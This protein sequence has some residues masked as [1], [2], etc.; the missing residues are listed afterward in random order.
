MKTI[1]ILG[2]GCPSC[3]ATEDVVR[4]ALQQSGKEAAVEKVEDIQEIMKYNVLTTPVLVVDEEI[5]IKGRV[6]DV[7][8]VIE[9]LL[10]SKSKY[11]K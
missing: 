8:E 2:M 4:Q 11:L 7:N 5:K 10:M 1:K 6:P 3:Q 9:L